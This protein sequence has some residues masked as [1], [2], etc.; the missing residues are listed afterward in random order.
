[1]YILRFLDLDFYFYGISV[2]A[3]VCGFCAFSLPLFFL[4]VLS[5]SSFLFCFILFY[6]FS[7]PICFLAREGVKD[8]IW[9][10]VEV[11]KIGE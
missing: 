1:M 10:E 8:V 9:I 2:Y 5:C 6:Y 3:S 7:V 4:F 11:A